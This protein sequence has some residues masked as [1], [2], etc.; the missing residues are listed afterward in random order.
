MQPAHKMACIDAIEFGQLIEATWPILPQVSC[1]YS[2]EKFLFSLTSTF[3]F[4]PLAGILQ[5]MMNGHGC[6]TMDGLVF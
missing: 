3:Y 5:W 6:E 2:I 4:P 1:V